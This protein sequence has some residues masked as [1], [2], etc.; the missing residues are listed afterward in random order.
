[1]SLLH[2]FARSPPSNPFINC[3]LPS[4]LDVPS[5]FGRMFYLLSY[6][7][8]LSSQ[9][10]GTGTVVFRNGPHGRNTFTHPP[11]QLSSTNVSSN[12]NPGPFR[13]ANFRKSS[14]PF[15]QKLARLWI[16]S[17]GNQKL[18]T[19]LRQRTGEIT[20]WTGFSGTGF[21]GRYEKIAQGNGAFNIL[22]SVEKKK[23]AGWRRRWTDERHRTSDV[24]RE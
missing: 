2:D 19:N 22:F 5:L 18:V 10:S 1:M 8:I 17:V 23:A 16:M 20:S 4:R 6:L 3:C 12:H 9:L 15:P 14:C 11:S 21:F 24:H 7:F 13:G